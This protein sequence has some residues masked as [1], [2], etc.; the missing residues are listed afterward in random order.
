L[1]LVRDH[2]IQRYSTMR[3]RDSWCPNEWRTTKR[4]FHS[5]PKLFP[6]TGGPGSGKTTVLRELAKVGFQPAPEV[7]GQI[8]Q[9]QM[10]S[11][12]TALPWLNRTVYTGLVRERS[13]GSYLQHTPAQEPTFCERGIP[14]TLGFARLIDLR[15]DDQV[16]SIQMACRQCRY[17]L[18]LFVA[19]PWKEIHRTDSQRKQDFEEAVRTFDRMAEIYRCCDYELTELPKATHSTEPASS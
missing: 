2:E 18:L 15:E 4:I 3:P 1:I 13:I 14:D 16:S 8:I 12:G 6:V 5:N 19:P 11:A 9:E 10:R 17:A 7:A